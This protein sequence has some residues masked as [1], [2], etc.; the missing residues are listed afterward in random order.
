MKVWAK[1]VI[2]APKKAFK[3]SVLVFLCPCGQ[4]SVKRRYKATEGRNRD[5]GWRCSK[6]VVT[7]AKHME[8]RLKGWQR[9]REAEDAPKVAEGVQK[10]VKNRVRILVGLLRRWWKGRKQRGFQSSKGKK[11]TKW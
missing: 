8:Q 10:A 9:H 11:V 4:M 1:R 3:A 5:R 6:D 7:E 2:F